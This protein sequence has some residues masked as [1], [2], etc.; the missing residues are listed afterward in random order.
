M[1]KREITIILDSV[2]GI[3]KDIARLY[4][5]LNEKPCARNT[6]R[7]KNTERE[8]IELKKGRQSGVNMFFKTAVVIV[9]LLQA[10][11]MYKGL[12]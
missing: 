12:K 10:Y 8:I 6:E 11:L 7:I 1:G 2:D 3:R 4:D 9:S 5:R